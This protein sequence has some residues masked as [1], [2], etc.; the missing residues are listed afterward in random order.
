MA[1]NT[2]GGSSQRQ[3]QGDDATYVLLLFAFALSIKILR[4]TL[5]SLSSSIF[6]NLSHRGANSAGGN[7]APSTGQALLTEATLARH[8]ASLQSQ[9]AQNVDENVRIAR[10]Q[11][12]GRSLG[13]ELPRES[14]EREPRDVPLWVESQ[15]RW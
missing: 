15:R 2:N 3:N 13:F 9:G 8:N 14:L 5:N 7:G 12:A 10:I 1:S 11:E 4:D 6:F